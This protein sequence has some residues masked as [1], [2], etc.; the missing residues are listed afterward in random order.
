MFDADIAGG[1]MFSSLLN[2]LIAW[3]SCSSLDGKTSAFFSSKL[4]QIECILL[5]KK[6]IIASNGQ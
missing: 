2:S 5:Q 4:S 6:W 1:G 3:D